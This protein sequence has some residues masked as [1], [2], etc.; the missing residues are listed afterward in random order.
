[1]ICRKYQALTKKLTE[2]L[3]MVSFE[4]G[5]GNISCCM[6]STYVRSG[7][8]MS[9]QH[10]VRFVYRTLRELSHATRV[11]FELRTFEFSRISTSKNVVNES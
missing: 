7:R 1:M 6:Y 11:T 2:L 9:V 4:A 8:W 5:G 10:T 3:L